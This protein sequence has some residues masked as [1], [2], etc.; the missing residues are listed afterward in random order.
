ML[1]QHQDPS[2]PNTPL[3]SGFAALR[4]LKIYQKFDCPATPELIDNFPLTITPVTDD[5]AGLLIALSELSNEIPLDKN[6]L[7]YPVLSQIMSHGLLLARG[8]THFNVQNRKEKIAALTT[9]IF[10]VTIVAKNPLHNRK[11]GEA[12]TAAQNMAAIMDI[13]QLK[14]A[15]REL[16]VIATPRTTNYKKSPVAAPVLSASEEEALTEQQL[17]LSNEYNNYLALISNF[18]DDKNAD[19]KLEELLFSTAS[20]EA[21]KASGNLPEFCLL[22][23]E[24]KRLKNYSSKQAPETIVYHALQSTL[25]D[26]LELALEIGSA[27]QDLKFYAT[28]KEKLVAI[29]NTV[30]DMITLVNDFGNSDHYKKLVETSLVMRRKI[31]GIYLTRKE[32]RLLCGI[33][34]AITTAVSIA[35]QVSIFILLCAMP[36]VGAV[37]TATIVAS[38]V[39][40]AIS[41]AFG[42][43]GLVNSLVPES[44]KQQDHSK[45]IYQQVIN[46]KDQPAQSQF[47]QARPHQPKSLRK[48][49][50]SFSS[51]KLK[52]VA[53]DHNEEKEE[54]NPTILQCAE[55]YKALKKLKRLEIPN[56]Y[57]AYAKLINEFPLEI[58]PVTLDLVGV[59]LELSALSETI[60]K[61]KGN[62]ANKLIESTLNSIILKS[63]ALAKELADLNVKNRQEKLRSLKN[64]L[65][66]VNK[67]TQTP[68]GE[69]INMEALTLAC[70]ALNKTVK[71][72]DLMAELLSF[73]TVYPPQNVAARQ[74]GLVP[75]LSADEEAI[76]DKKASRVI[77]GYNGYL[78]D[79]EKLINEIEYP[80]V[81]LA[82]LKA[83]VYY[84]VINANYS[85]E[86]TLLLKS[87]NSLKTYLD[88]NPASPYY[89]PLLEMRNQAILLT[90]ELGLPL[91]LTANKKTKIIAL[92]ETI[93][94]TMLFTNHPNETAKVDLMKAAEKMRN[95]IEGSYLYRKE[96]RLIAGILGAVTAVLT[97]AALAASVLLLVHF[98]PVMLPLTL[99]GLSGATGVGT[100]LFGLLGGSLLK[101]AIVPANPG[102]Q[103]NSKTIYQQAK[104]LTPTIFNKPKVVVEKKDEPLATTNTTRRIVHP[105]F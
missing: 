6:Y 93:A 92:H 49:Q 61:R 64:S 34:G 71:A 32:N 41:T 79:L 83:P 31:E 7:L 63:L 72:P 55:G 33:L 68:V 40:L 20:F 25:L 26:S 56:N 11:P 4:K 17:A 30:K 48:V 104:Q 77:R 66:E 42:I 53:E 99:I 46:L 81:L 23:E 21:I 43:G 85:A 95:T 39:G 60:I 74:L 29:T 65:V 101:Y 90:F 62:A 8:L 35:A 94:A 75:R 28:R 24:L 84:E 98:A 96:N 100:S 102:A 88:K 91:S 54:K 3:A 12:N 67:V 87:L 50:M 36:P 59:L 82:D 51:Q 73:K 22:L 69:A 2:Q 47:H 52:S 14:T 18:K 19:S 86:F 78:Q 76:L 103:D 89:A 13:S 45:D 1:S 16:T 38:Y 97:I 70:E 9:V 57:D 58:S 15:V 105:V 80:A 5:V 10:Q 44:P 37:V 27:K